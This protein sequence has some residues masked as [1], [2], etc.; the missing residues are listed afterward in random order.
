MPLPIKSRYTIAEAAKFIASAAGEPVTTSQVIDWGTQGLYRLYAPVK[1]ATVRQAGEAD[2]ARIRDSIVEVRPSCEQAATLGRGERVGLPTCWR[3]GIECNFMRQKGEYS[4]GW[5]TDTVYFGAGGLVLLGVEL[6]AF[7]A[8]IAKP[9]QA[10]PAT[11]PM[12]DGSQTLFDSGLSVREFKTHL[13]YVPALLEWAKSKRLRLRTTPPLDG[14]EFVHIETL[15]CA[16]ERHAMSLTHEQARD[17]V[18]NDPALQARMFAG[19][20]VERGEFDN[21]VKE[22]PAWLVQADA[23]SQ[24]RKLF[25]AAIQAG[26]LALLDFGSKLPI[27]TVPAQNTATPAP[28]VADGEAKP[29]LQVDPRDPEPDQDWYTPAR[30]FARQLV[31]GDSTLLVKKLTLADKVSNSLKGVGILKRGNKD[32]FNASTVLKAFTNVTLG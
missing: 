23:H 26:E 17:I 3:D 13:L 29:W 5:R 11:A 7:T 21:Y 12:T 18:A 6:A 27:D 28:V 31:S 24:W 15:L 22:S 1:W 9:Q 14:Y 25:A 2:I 4:P 30:Y 32:R 10:A 8:S 20:G 19:L 16:I